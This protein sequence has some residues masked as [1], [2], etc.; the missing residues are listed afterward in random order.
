MR[1]VFMAGT[2]V[3]SLGQ[4]WVKTG[5]G[6]I[7]PQTGGAR[8]GSGWAQSG[9]GIPIPAPA[10]EDVQTPPPPVAY[11]RV[12]FGRQ[13]A[14]YESGFHLRPLPLR[15]GQDEQAPPINGGPGKDGRPLGRDG[16]PVDR[17]GRPEEVGPPEKVGFRGKAQI[18]YEE[19]EE[20]KDLLDEI[21]R[22][23]SEEEA[24][25][26]LESEACAR[27]IAE[28]G[29]YPIV[30]RLRERLTQ[31]LAAGNREAMFTISQGELTVTGKAVDCAEAIGRKRTVETVAAGG[32]GAGVLALLL[33]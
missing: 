3:E 11:S 24:Q 32:L 31:Y 25:A 12:L 29:N 30:E 4:T 2:P 21:L 1:N 17:G 27:N 8:R 15:L 13:P 10:P 7:V 19:A 22:P 23:L 9:W 33:L 14:A 18:S 16:R 28:A 20:L 5:W 26:V 6:W